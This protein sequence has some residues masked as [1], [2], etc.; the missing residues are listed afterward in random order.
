MK[1]LQQWLLFLVMIIMCSAAQAVTIKVGQSTTLTGPT[2]GSSTGALYTWTVPSYHV[3]TSSATSK[4]ITVTG[5]SAGTVTLTCTVKWQTYNSTIKTYVYESANVKT[6]SYT[7]TVTEDSSGSGSSSS[8]EPNSI[9]LNY[10]SVSLQVGGTRQLSATV[11]PS[12]ASQSVTWSVTSGS[13][14][15]TVSSSGLVTAKAAGTATVRAT[16]TANTSVYKNCTV[17]VT[18]PTSSI[19]AGTWSG[20]TLTIDANATYSGYT[21]PYSN[22][23][24]YSTTQMLYTPTEIGKSGTINSIAFKVSSASSFSTSE[25]K[26]YLGHKSGTFSSSSNYVTSSNLTLVYSGTPTLGQTT[27]WE[28]LTFNQGTF[29]YNGTDNLV[30]VVTRK[31]DNYSGSLKYYNYNTGSGYTLYRQSDSDAGYGEVTNTSNGYST[32]TNRPA[33]RMVF[34]TTPTSISLNTTSVSLEVGGTKQ[35]TATVLPSN[36]S[37]S[38][39]WSV[40][41]GSSYVSVSTSGLVTAKAPGTATVRA[42]STA[43]PSVYKNCTVTVTAATTA[44][45]AIDATNF[46]DENFR[47]YL[48]SQSFGQD[49]VLTES[50]IAGVKSIEV[51][52]KSISTLKGIEHF[53]ELTN[54]SCYGNHL[55]SLDVSKNTA[56]TNLNC[57]GN[58]LTSLDVSKNTTLTELDCAGNQLTS[59]D[60]SKNT[61]LTQLYCNNN[62]LTSLDVS[63]NTALTWL[64]CYMNQ[65]TSLD[66]S[67]NTALTKL[68]CF[69]N[70]LT[71]LDVSKNTALTELECENNQ[72]TSLDVSKN[73]ALTRL[74]CGNN[75]LTS[76]DVSKN[77]ALTVLACYNNQLTSLDVSKNTALT[78]LSCF[79]NKI[80]GSNMDNLINSLRQNN[81]TSKYNFYVI[82]NSNGDEGNIC[83]K[84]Q[85]AAVKAKGWTPRYY[86]GSSWV[87]YEGSEDEVPASDV[88]INETNFPDEN[89]R[90]WLLQQSYG[91]DGILTQSE[92][93]GITSIDIRSKQIKNLKGI[94]YFT[95]LTTLKCGYNQLTSLDVSNCTSLTILEC[96]YNQ[97]TSLDVSNCTAL[98]DL[99]CHN[100]QLTSLDVFKN[101]ALKYLECSSNQLTSLDVS[102]NTALTNLNCY[103]NK[104]NC[105][106]MDNLINSLRQNNTTSTYNFRVIDNRNGDEGNV[107]TKSQVAAVKA[108]GWTPNYY[109]GSSWVEYEG[110]EDNIFI[111]GLYYAIISANDINDA[112]NEDDELIGVFTPNTDIAA[113]TS[114]PKG[115]E[116]TGDVIIPSSIEHNGITYAVEALMADAFAGTSITSVL[117]P[118]SI[119]LIAAGAFQNCIGLTN[120]TIPSSVKCIFE[121]A[122]SGCTGLT[123]IISEI[124]EPFPVKSSVFKNVTATLYVPK[125][126]KAKYEATAGWNQLMIEEMEPFGLQDG[127][128]FTATTVEGVEMTF[129]VISAAN[130]TCQ[131]GTGN[132]YPNAIDQYKTSGLVTIPAIING[133]TV[134]SIADYAFYECY[135]VT[136]FTIPN[137]VKAIGRS[138]FYGCEGIAGI[139]I[140]SSVTTI[141]NTAFDRSGLSSIV[142]P[143]NVITMGEYNQEIEGETNVEIIPVSA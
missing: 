93:N 120:I 85:V 142:Y 13:S 99:Q 78:S 59:L 6:Q 28:T 68:N 37:Q 129:K 90:N 124:E 47:S 132:G 34:T 127:D 125:G 122:F 118:N 86:N 26:V 79:R 123:S 67:K 88:A 114:A 17:T 3:S 44:D 73:T 50:E 138:A 66:M 91:S 76:F 9:S 4:T 16:S 97:L 107:C 70:Q 81:T 1:Y 39:S 23:Y 136:S 69:S 7:V 117:L 104:I 111:N 108:K 116:Y 24:K 89:F 31:S 74:G 46:P 54:L 8:T 42:A 135:K 106:N 22:F 140:P 112:I 84:S 119:R 92:I 21:V 45:I 105:S 29:N 43:N 14:Y 62:Q 25:V 57:Y 71:S 5:T 2:P 11:S 101:T 40:P 27:G 63:K 65:L 33:I 36:A 131:V 72:L 133:F 130:K 110:S 109:N 98:T 19:V 94:E 12:G 64:D 58:H 56:L 48:L 61:A 35:L 113:I 121:D 38:V 134:T 75:Q 55:T 103:R 87:E 60:V 80:K 141:G 96:Y 115:S 137:S 30:V 102:K 128:I 10:T 139:T 20:N 52:Y 18:E 32:S 83:M 41:S 100:N 77:T 126:T 15:V 143:E 49:G 51:G 53:T 95:A 82:D